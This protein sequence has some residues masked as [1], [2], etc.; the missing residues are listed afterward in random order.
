MEVLANLP[1]LQ[2]DRH[3]DHRLGKG[4]FQARDTAKLLSLL[5]VFG[6]LSAGLVLQG[7][8]LLPRGWEVRWVR[9]PDLAGMVVAGGGHCSGPWMSVVS[10]L[11]GLALAFPLLLG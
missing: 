4:P 8:E 2:Q 11:G 3:T 7:A 10:S 6:T 5:F 1:V 9:S